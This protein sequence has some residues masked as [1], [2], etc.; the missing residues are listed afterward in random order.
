MISKIALILLSIFALSIEQESIELPLYGTITTDKE[1]YFYINTKR[2]LKGENL[3][4]Y[5][6][7]ESN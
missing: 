6:T 4:V 1:I 7:F 5:I 2:Y 3:R